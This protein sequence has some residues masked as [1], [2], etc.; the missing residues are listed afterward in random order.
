MEG[1]AN[2]AVAD[3]M[4][5]V[6]VSSSA[7]HKPSGPGVRIASVTRLAWPPDSTGLRDSSRSSRFL[8]LGACARKGGEAPADRRTC[9]RPRPLVVRLGPPSLNPGLG[10]GLLEDRRAGRGRAGIGRAA[11]DCGTHAAVVSGAEQMP[12]TAPPAPQRPGRGTSSEHLTE[13]PDARL[14]QP[15]PGR[16]LPGRP[17]TSS[18]AR[19]PGAVLDWRAPGGA[20]P[21]PA[22][23]LARCG[24]PTRW[25]PSRVPSRSLLASR[26][27]PRQRWY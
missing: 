1:Q 22:E 6:A 13:C 24:P 12:Y 4:S 14:R 21:A 19:A 15:R 27:R 20:G 7:R 18:G 25:S 8:A 17:G 16:L 5:L 23:P 10:D 2:P 26:R 3:C 11:V 9:G